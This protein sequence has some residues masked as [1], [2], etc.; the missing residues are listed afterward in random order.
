MSLD[1]QR[2]RSTKPLTVAV[3]GMLV[4]ILGV[5]V[6][7]AIDRSRADGWKSGTAHLGEQQI[8]IESGGWTYGAE[9]SIPAWID[10]Q[11]TRHDGGW[12][13]CLDGPVG[14]DRA[15]RFRAPTVHVDGG[16]FRPIVVV[17]CRG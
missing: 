5:A 11:G 2:S 3:A 4:L 7:V 16:S 13:D 8:S 6:G 15:V 12:P 14:S 10:T 9:G 1:V 17:D